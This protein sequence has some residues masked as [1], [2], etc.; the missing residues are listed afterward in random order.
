MKN[1]KENFRGYADILSR[2]DLSK[3]EGYSKDLF[4]NY[5]ALSEDLLAIKNMSDGDTQKIKEVIHASYK[6]LIK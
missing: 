6:L 1:T 5:V 4:I 2:Y 3:L